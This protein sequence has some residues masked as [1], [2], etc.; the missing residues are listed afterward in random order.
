[1]C[2]KRWICGSRSAASRSPSRCRSSI[3]STRTIRPAS[4]RRRLQLAHAARPR[5]APPRRRRRRVQHPHGVTGGNRRQQCLLLVESV[6]TYPAGAIQTSHLQAL[7][8]V[9]APHYDVSSSRSTF[10]VSPHGKWRG[11]TL[12]V[13]DDES[14]GISGDVRGSHCASTG[15][16]RAQEPVAALLGPA[17]PGQGRACGRRRDRPAHPDRDLRRAD[18]IESIIGHPQNA[19]LQQHDRRVRCAARAE[20][21]SSGSAPTRPG[22]TSSCGRC[23][24]RARRCSSASSLP[25]SRC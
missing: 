7:G 16:G 9:L 18:R 12:A 2:V 1:M 14:A 24:A 3:G 20:Q 5:P 17:P 15:R 13:G 23:T 10:S 11:I 22:A 21:L 6:E 8:R 19:T 25:A 4:A